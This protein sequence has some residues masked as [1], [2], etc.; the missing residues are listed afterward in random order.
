MQPVIFGGIHA[1]RGVGGA[2][3]LPRVCGGLDAVA[4]VHVA[5]IHGDAVGVAGEEDH[6]VRAAVAA[7]HLDKVTGSGLGLTLPVLPEE[8]PVR[9]P[10]REVLPEEMLI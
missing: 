9:L 10:T 2:E 7:P 6:G 4:A 5:L 8:S 3:F 1:H